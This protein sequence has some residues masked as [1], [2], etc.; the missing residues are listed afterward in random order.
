M[1]VRYRCRH[2]ETR[3]TLPK[4]VHMYA[5]KVVCRNCGRELHYVCADRTTKA[6]AKDRCYCDAYHYPH[7]KGRGLCR[8][9]EME[10]RELEYRQ[11]RLEVEQLCDQAK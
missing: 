3:R 6:R 7:G 2:C 8:P 10:R 11:M 4:P 5:R 9:G 1:K